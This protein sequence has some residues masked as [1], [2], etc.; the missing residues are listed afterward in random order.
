MRTFFLSF[1]ALLLLL[2]A[3]SAQNV[4]AATPT[5]SAP[6]AGDENTPLRQ[7]LE[8]MQKAVAALEQRLTAQEKAAQEKKEETKQGLASDQP[9]TA[10]LA[11]Q[12]KDLDHPVNLTDS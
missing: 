4:P 12:V 6:A 9:T 10:E 1:V 11:T 8:Q 2:S 7:E 5:Q 3:A